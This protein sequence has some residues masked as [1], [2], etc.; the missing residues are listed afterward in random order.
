M[1]TRFPNQV[2]AHVRK[3]RSVFGL[4]NALLYLA[5]LPTIE[6]STSALTETSFWAAQ[7]ME[8]HGEDIGMS[9]AF[10]MWC[11]S[12]NTV[13]LTMKGCMLLLRGG[14]QPTEIEWC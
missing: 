1:Q 9:I 11:L 7:T 2:T 10:Q 3:C 12:P 14:G 4:Y 6:A 5:G 13:L 8:S